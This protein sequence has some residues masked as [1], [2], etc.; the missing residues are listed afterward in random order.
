[1]R[2]LSAFQPGILRISAA[3]APHSCGLRRFFA[4]GESRGA[5]EKKS[6]KFMEKAR[7]IL[8]K[9]GIIER[10]ELWIARV[11]RARASARV[12]NK[13]EADTT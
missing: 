2:R 4:F 10:M 11:S 3:A 1:M 9:L 5:M 12:D 6:K 7:F 8:D 13:K